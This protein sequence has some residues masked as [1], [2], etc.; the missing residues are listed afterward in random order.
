M[1]IKIKSISSLITIII[2]LILSSPSLKNVNS[3]LIPRQSSS[4]GCAKI[5]TDIAANVTISYEDVK[6]CWESLPY[7]NEI[8]VSVQNLNI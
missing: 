8:A 3:H 5:G 2:F 7:N 4:T 1:N 6:T